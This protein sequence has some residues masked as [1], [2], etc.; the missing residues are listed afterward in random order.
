MSAGAEGSPTTTGSHRIAVGIFGAALPSPR[1]LHDGGALQGTPGDK[2]KDGMAHCE[3]ST[4]TPSRRRSVL[5]AS[6]STGMKPVALVM[7]S[8]TKRLPGI[9]GTLTGCVM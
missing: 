5:S 3:N 6:T 4:H 9:V 8:G 2:V 7:R 1:C